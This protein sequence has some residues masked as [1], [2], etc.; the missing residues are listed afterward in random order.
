MVVA[1]TMAGIAFAEPV[2]PTPLG[3]PLHWPLAGADRALRGGLGDARNGRFHAGLDLSTARRNG[4]SVAAPADGWVERVRTSGVGYGRSLY[5]RTDDGRLVV[6]GHLDAFEPRLAA[7]VDSVQRAT[8]GYEQD[9]WPPAGRFRYRGGERVAW[10]GESGAG[11]PH[12]HV[13]VRHGDFALNPLLAG[14]AVPDAVAP[15][16]ASVTLEP[17][18]ESSWVA[19]SAA[20]RTHRFGAATDTLVVEG[21]VRLTVLASDD[22]DGAT[23]LPVHTVGARWQGEWVACRMDSLSWAGEMS[24]SEWL[25]D[26]GRVAGTGGVVIEA[27]VGPLAPRFLVASRTE[28]RGASLVRVAAG[29]PARV[30]EVMAR[31]AAGNLA[32]R[33]VWLRG[34]RAHE[35]GPD[36]STPKAAVA[37]KAR[38]ADPR[39]SFAS[40]PDLRVRVRVSGAP[41]G[42]RDVRFERAGAAAEANAPVRAS[43]DGADW[44]AVLHANGLPDADGLWVKGTLPGGGAWWHRASWGLWPIGSAM[45]ARLDDGATLSAPPGS[46]WEA[47]VMLVR[48]VPTAG[49]PPGGV[50]VRAAI[51]A[52]PVQPPLRRAVSVTLPVPA[53]A[54]REHVVMMR[55]DGGGE[56]W[57]WVEARLDT[58]AG[59]YTGESAR[60]GQFALVRDDE[61]PVVVPLAARAPVRGAYSTWALEARVT[62]DVSGIAGRR[63]ALRVDGEPV[64]VEWDA[65]HKLL[66]WR[67]LAPPAPGR[68]TAEFEAVDRAGHR[69]VR[70][71]T[72][73]VVSR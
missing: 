37:A 17:L 38:L 32:T 4:A 30:L 59:T 53:G 19:R 27:P 49:L 9:L 14:Y 12:L 70:R 35:R 66:R 57:E 63:C 73:V 43:R 50:A 45:V 55:R 60:L 40:L 2:V 26:D 20:P 3:G 71:T 6:F 64:P 23:G 42:L 15:R 22:T 67:P 1:L 31:D 5:I 36:T 18:D 21:R 68:H 11:P 51:E 61:P 69:T 46:E 34:P 16:I 56:R 8:V 58:V 41:A 72:F 47:G 24:Q 7:Y 54:P 39:W 25:L 62:E 28:A 48:G 10:S 52:L 65:E 29:E 44:V 33:R 13:E